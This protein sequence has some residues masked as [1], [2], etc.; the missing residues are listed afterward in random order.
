[1]F[2]RCLA[3]SLILLGTLRQVGLGSSNPVRHQ[4]LW[5]RGTS[6]WQLPRPVV[7]DT[8]HLGLSKAMEY[9]QVTDAFP[10]LVMI[11]WFVATTIEV[12]KPI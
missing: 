1:M 10:S 5:Q 6:A 11:G 4:S 7:D 8:V 9:P 2:Q 3:P 12:D